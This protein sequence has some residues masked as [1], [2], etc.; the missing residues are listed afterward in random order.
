[1][2]LFDLF[3]EEEAIAIAAARTDI[4][5][6]NAAYAALSP[7]ERNARREAYETQWSFL[8]TLWEAEDDAEDEDE[9]E[10]DDSEYD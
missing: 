6:E 5:A 2:N 1:M 8:D 7:S 10:D 9:D 4:A 3:A